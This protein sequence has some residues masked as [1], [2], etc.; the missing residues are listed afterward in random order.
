MATA[1]IKVLVLYHSLWG[2]VH[3]L[4][5]AVAEG[6]REV[7][8][9]EVTVRRVPET[10]PDNVL[11][12][13]HALET[14]KKLDAEVPVLTDP[15]ELAHYDGIFFGTGTRYGNMTAQMKTFIDQTGGLWAKYALEGKVATVFTSS[16]SQHG[17]QESTI[18]TFHV[19]LLHHGFTIVGLP[20]SCDSTRGVEAAKGCGPYGA[21]TVTGPDG[22]R[23]P[24]ESDL[25]GARFQG[26]H[27]ATV[28][29]NLVL[30]KHHAPN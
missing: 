16:G 9:V 2:H 22:S 8:G 7:K 3:Q 17:G 14:K 18:L 15:S 6:A 26:R 1:P 28:T 20:Y 19:V 25:A 29:R 23:Q 12:K 24:S 11:E 10:L 13:M 27:A 21:S 30:G 4:A 5:K